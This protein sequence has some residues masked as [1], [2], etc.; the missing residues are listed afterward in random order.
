MTAKE[1]I[2]RRAAKEIQDGDMVNLGI[3][4][5]T[6]VPA[7]LEPGVE[8]VFQSDNGL[9]GIVDQGQTDFTYQDP[10][11]KQVCLAPYGSTFDSLT[12]F[13][14]IGG[15]H[16]DVTMLGALQVDE[17]G[18]LAN[19]MIPGKLVPGMGG[20]MDLVCG[21]KK[22]IIVMEHTNKG[23]SKIVKT[24]TLPLT[25][26]RCVHTIITELATFVVQQDGLVLTDLQD[27]VTLDEVRE[28]TDADFRIEITS[29][30]TKKME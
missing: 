21:A 16:I 27:G 28:K 29:G 9:L 14:M 19:W 17:Q 30:N 18:N 12:A 24:C 10:G 5:P 4:I 15:G 11:G 7:Y 20:A 26:P 8:A 23:R 22:V 13:D 6:M 25:A 3:G 2:A 1:I